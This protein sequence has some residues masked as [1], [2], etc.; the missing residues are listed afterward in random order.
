VPAEGGEYMIGDE[1]G[2]DVG[3]RAT[4]RAGTRGDR[5][6]DRAADRNSDRTSDRTSQRSSGRGRGVDESSVLV[7]GLGRFGSATAHALSR[8]GHPVLAVDRDPRLVQEW[9]SQL[10]RVVEADSTSMEALEQL[11]AT[12]F[13]V[14]IVGIGTSIE[15]SVLTASNLVDLGIPHVW[16]KAI[17]GKHGKILE[18]IGVDRVVYPEADA[19]ERV[20]HLVTGKL[21]DYMEVDEKFAVV[22]MRPP[23]EAHGFTLAQSQ[24]R[25]K[26]GVTVVGVKSPGK[27]FTYA[28]QDTM[29]SRHDVLLVAGRSELLERFAARP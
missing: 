10:T 8:L 18:R 24:L 4:D 21:M 3:G 29:I 12:D 27:E 22:K 20:A 16:A 26:Y 1:A 25:K 15:A 19:G 6:T 14:A 11:G 17:S 7:C 13:G 5:T 28:G 23:T 2:G 9:A